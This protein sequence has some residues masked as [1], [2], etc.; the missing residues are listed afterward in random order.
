MGK[1][2]TKKQASTRRD[3]TDGKG[4]QEYEEAPVQFC[5]MDQCFNHRNLKVCSR[6]KVASY[7]SVECQRKNWKMH[8][9]TCDRNVSELEIVDGE[10]P[11]LQRNL[12]HWVARFDATLHGACIR[13]LRLKTEWERIDQGGLMIWVEPRPHA[14]V[15]ARCRIINLGVFQ[16]A[17][18]LDLLGRLGMGMAERFRDEVLPVHNAE[19]ER[20][21]K[22]SGGRADFSFVITIAGNLG[23]DKLEGDHPITWRFTP[24]DIYRD[25][26]A[27]MSMEMYETD[28]MQEL[29]A[30]VNEDRPMKHGSRNG[31]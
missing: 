6:C 11:L 18:I 9:W 17:A 21:R 7:C 10:E 30:Q 29:T 19:R 24:V 8:K 16:H 23:A 20:L 2:S 28:W 12:R 27:S 13:A 4:D 25:A 5:S 15:G 14:N 1:K 22:S 31:A 3:R 26:A